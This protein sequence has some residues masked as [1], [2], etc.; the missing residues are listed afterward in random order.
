MPVITLTGVAAKLGGDISA[1]AARR[2]KRF[3]DRENEGHK[4]INALRDRV[5]AD[6]AVPPELRVSLADQLPSKIRTE[7]QAQGALALLLDG[8]RTDEAAAALAQ[9]IERVTWG[10]V[11]WPDSFGPREFGAVVARHAVDGVNLVKATDRE[12]A[13]VAHRR[14]LEMLKRIES[15]QGTLKETMLALDGLDRRADDAAASQAPSKPIVSD[16]RG[17][18]RIVFRTDMIPDEVSTYEAVPAIE[19]AEPIAISWPNLSDAMYRRLLSRRTRLRRELSERGI[20]PGPDLL[21]AIREFDQGLEAGQIR[22]EHSG[23]RI[24][25]MW[26]GMASGWG[27]Q[28]RDAFLGALHNFLVIANLHA[29]MAMGAVHFDDDPPLPYGLRPAS[30]PHVWFQNPSVAEALGENPPFWAASIKVA[31]QSLYIYAPRR[32]V[33][34]LEHELFKRRPTISF[35]MARFVVPQVEIYM[36]Q[37]PEALIYFPDDLRLDKLRDEN[38]EEV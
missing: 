25:M 5:R 16:A 4:L 36:L 29:L 21:S 35:L 11:S 27:L 34:D 26:D 1:A 30:D 22:R 8:T 13:N 31:D 20:E 15:G 9:V 2:G 23:S 10:S 7:P 6:A 18:A 12:A 17:I 37:R 3:W 24:P 28:R 32:L 19:R 38:F 14:I 33:E